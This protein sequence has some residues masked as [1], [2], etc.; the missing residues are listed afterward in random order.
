MNMTL[1]IVIPVYNVEKY[2][3]QCMN[4]IVKQNKFNLVEV[5]LI[6]DGSTDSSFSICEDYEKKFK[7]IKVIHQQNSGQAIARNNGIKYSKGDYIMFMDSDDYF[8]DNNIISKII[9]IINIKEPDLI[10][11]GYKKIYE[12]SNLIKEKK[13]ISGNINLKKL[14]KT[15]YYKGCP[16]DKVIKKKI[17]IDNDIFFPA[18]MLSEDIDFCA[19]LLSYINSEKVEIIN[20]NPYMYRQRNGSTTKNIKSSH[21]NDIY[22]I[23]CRYYVKGAH[24]DCIINNYLAYEYSMTIGI[25]NSKFVSKKLSNELIRKYYSLSKLLKYDMCY[26]VKIVNFIY[27]FLGIKL[28][29]KILGIFINWRS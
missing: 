21:I 10:M 13:K 11:Y 18:G 29:S 26:K 28:T 24:K 17:L 19:K 12:N 23:L 4:S 1:S 16:W 7:N 15:N 22:N 27:H 5:L 20:E 14:I 6:D 3:T 9:N 25:I 2:L 8:N